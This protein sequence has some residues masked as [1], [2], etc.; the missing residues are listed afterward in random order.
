MRAGN[1]LE[2]TVQLL[3]DSL[4]RIAPSISGLPVVAEGYKCYDEVRFDDHTK[5]SMYF[6][7]GS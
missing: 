6:S 2:Q 7:P 4:C 1:G 3:K 5:T